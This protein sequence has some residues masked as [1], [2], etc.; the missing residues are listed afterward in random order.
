MNITLLH[1]VVS[2]VYVAWIKFARYCPA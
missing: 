2:D 1:N